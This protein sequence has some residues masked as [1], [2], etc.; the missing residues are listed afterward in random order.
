MEKATILFVDDEPAILSSL[1]FTFQKTYNVLTAQNGQA[2]IELVKQQ[3]V[4]VI[5]SDQRMPEMAGTEVLRQ[6]KAISPYTMRMLLTGYSDLEAAMAS[7]NTGEVF[8]YV[9]K[10][11]NTDKLKETIAFAIQ[12]SEKFQ[13]IATRQKPAPS[14]SA[15]SGQSDILFI[16]P[17]AT[18]LTALRDL[19]KG[20]YTVHTAS[21]ADEAFQIL[22][23]KPVAVIASEVNLGETDGVDFVAA[24]KQEY[25]N[26]VSILLSDNH[27]A[28]TAI[29]LINE[30]QAFRYLVKPFQRDM[31]KDVMQKA[32][33][34]HKIFSNQPALN[35]KTME[36]DV[37]SARNS[38]NHPLLE[39]LRQARERLNR[40]TTY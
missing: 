27:D 32:V 30:G 1:Q 3:R 31:L 34:Q 28:N 35:T 19:F 17:N 6:V 4:H 11:W 26:I 22:K 36:Q 8:R 7:V 23:T 29:R 25:P 15:N 14:P 24:I 40:R 10:P 37:L 2:A 39:A 38:T 5:I 33:T 20:D 18:H 9:N 13:E 16:E 12:L 21:T